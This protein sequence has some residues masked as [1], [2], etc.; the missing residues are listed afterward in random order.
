LDFDSIESKEI[1]SK[2]YIAV[3]KKQSFKA[4]LIIKQTKAYN[5]GGFYKGTLQII[6][7]KINST[8]KVHGQSG[9]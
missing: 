3:Y 7:N 4:I 2:S 5:E 6:G 1:D 8:F 9:C